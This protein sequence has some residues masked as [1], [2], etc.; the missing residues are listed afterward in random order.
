MFGAAHF[1]GTLTNHSATANLTLAVTSSAGGTITPTSQVVTVPARNVTPAN[2]DITVDLDGVPAG[3]DQTFT[4]T[5]TDHDGL[6]GTKTRELEVTHPNPALTVTAPV[7]NALVHGSTHFTGSATNNSGTDG[8]TL[9][10]EVNGDPFATASL[11]IAAGATGSF[12]VTKDVSPLDIGSDVFVLTVTDAN[13]RTSD[14]GQPATSA[15]T[16]RRS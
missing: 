1:T 13:N 11:P 6:V 4:V 9:D 16:T 8:L 3:V 14:R 5:A 12:D 10:I 7:A 15:S 2:F